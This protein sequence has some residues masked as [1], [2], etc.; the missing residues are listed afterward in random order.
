MKRAIIALTLAATGAAGCSTYGDE[1]AQPA[2]YA[3]PAEARADIRDRAGV[4][5]A[6]AMAM[7]VGT[8]IRVSLDAMNLPQ[9]TYAAH[10]HT[11]GRCDAPDFTTAGG[12]WNPTGAEHG[13][14]NPQGMHKG[15][16][17]NLLVGTDGRG[18]LEYTIE[19][20]DM[21]AMLDAD[22]AAL[23]IHTGADDYR[24]DPAGNAGGRMACGVF[25]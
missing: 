18:R 22:G 12:H 1:A 20:A 23:V 8:G 24:S 15:D 21:A 25:G 11:T 16:L 3:P 4:V 10:V 5:K 7:Q 2:D 9:G 13:K 19:S 17:P 14:D 6:S